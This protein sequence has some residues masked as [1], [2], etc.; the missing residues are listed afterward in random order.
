MPY[1][2]IIEAA[3]PAPTP[4]PIAT[5]TR[6]PNYKNKKWPDG[7]ILTHP[8]HFGNTGVVNV[9]QNDTLKL[10]SKPGT[11]STLVT[12]IP[13]NA[14]DITA[15]DQDQ[16]WDGD[17][18]WCPVEWHGFRGYVGRYYLPTEH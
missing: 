6:A 12:E 8:E 9:Q 16:A 13:S 17:S 2:N 14:T 5:P 1:V 18:W 11:K 4:T 15:F 10:R 7:R 3:T